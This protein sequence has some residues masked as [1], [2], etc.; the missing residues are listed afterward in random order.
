[1]GGGGE[2]WMATRSAVKPNQVS[3]D[4][5]G[6]G[7]VWAGRGGAGQILSS[8]DPCLTDR[9]QHLRGMMHHAQTSADLSG[10]RHG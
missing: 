2:I 10:V 7:R 6:L 4:R 5:I 9:G 8:L 3:L 1:M